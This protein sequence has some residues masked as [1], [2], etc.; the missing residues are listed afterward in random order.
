MEV[1]RFLLDPGDEC[2]EPVQREQRIAILPNPRERRMIGM[3]VEG[4]MTDGVEVDR[5]ATAARLGDEMMPL[6]ASTQWP[7]AQPAAIAVPF[8]ACPIHLKSGGLPPARRG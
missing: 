4:A 1:G 2:R 5:R 6:D 8:R 7:P 3:G